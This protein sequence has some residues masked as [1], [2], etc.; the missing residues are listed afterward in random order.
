MRRDE[1]ESN[2]PKK[3]PSD[4]S[5]G[6]MRFLPTSFICEAISHATH[7]VA[8]HG[9]FRAANNTDIL[10]RQNSKEQVPVGTIIPILV[11][12]GQRESRPWT[13]QAR[14]VEKAWSARA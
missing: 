1:I 4:V 2:K 8:N 5:G 10:D 12:H 14:W 6:G 11:I 7:V 13:S 3:S 9:P